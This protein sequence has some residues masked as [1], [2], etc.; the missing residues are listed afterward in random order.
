MQIHRFQQLATMNPLGVKNLIR[1]KKKKKG[2]QVEHNQLNLR[3]CLDKQGCSC[4]MEAPRLFF[5]TQGS[6]TKEQA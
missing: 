1:S 4:V 2:N 5:I 6:K 3:Q